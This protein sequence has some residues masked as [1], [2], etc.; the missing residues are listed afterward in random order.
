MRIQ[1]WD[2]FHRLTEVKTLYVNYCR[3]SLLAEFLRPNTSMIVRKVFSAR[4]LSSPSPVGTAGLYY[5]TR[6]AP[7]KIHRLPIQ[8]PRNLHFSSSTSTF[9]PFQ[10]MCMNRSKL[11]L[12]YRCQ[13]CRWYI[14]TVPI[15]SKTVRKDC[16]LVLVAELNQ[17]ITKSRKAC[18]FLLRPDFHNMQASID[19]ASVGETERKPG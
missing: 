1:F 4:P 14:R 5:E 9:C 7:A 11:L 2:L 10:P 8:L 6:T 17:D 19:K 13:N 3:V 16:P 15:I 12:T 18:N